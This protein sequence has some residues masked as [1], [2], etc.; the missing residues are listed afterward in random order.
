[1]EELRCSLPEDSVILYQDE[2][3]P[4]AAKTYGG[5]SWSSTQSKINKGQKT[6]GILNVFGVYD[7]TNNQMLTHSYKRKT[8]KQFLDFVKRVD[9]KYN[10]GVKQIFLIL[11]NASIHKSKIVKITLA[12]YYPRI[13]LVFLPTRCPELNLIEV[14]WMWMHRQAINNSVFQDERDIGKAVSDWTRYYNKKHGFKASTIS[15]QM[16]VSCQLHSF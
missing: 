2:K 16:D 13:H 11:D 6:N 5:P 7:Y 15:L 4:I 8:S 12:R 10:S 9:Q 1:M 14:R 3:G